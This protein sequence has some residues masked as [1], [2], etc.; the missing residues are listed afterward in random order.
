[1]FWGFPNWVR[2]LRLKGQGKEEG[3]ERERETCF[4]FDDTVTC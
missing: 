2:L 1:M 4:P 3:R